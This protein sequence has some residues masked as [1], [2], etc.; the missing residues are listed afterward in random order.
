MSTA[1]HIITPQIIL[2]WGICWPP[3]KQ[4]DMFARCDPM[5]LAFVMAQPDIT[6]LEKLWAICHALAY[7][8]EPGIVVNWTEPMPRAP[9]WY[10]PFHAATSAQETNPSAIQQVI[11][12]V[13]SL[14]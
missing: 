2:K 3:Q 6:Q 4:A 5:T 12:Q 11:D 10:W 13:A 1:D 8:N 7:W 9:T 14:L